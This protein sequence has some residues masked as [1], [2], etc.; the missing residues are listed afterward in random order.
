MLFRSYDDKK[1]NPYLNK[2]IGE[3]EKYFEE[4]FRYGWSQIVYWTEGSEQ[5]AHL[6]KADKKTI[7]TSITYL[8]DDYTG[9]ETYLSNEF[10]I[11]PKKGRTIFFHGMKYYH[12][13]S[14]IT[15]GGRYTLPIWYNRK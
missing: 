15:K 11:K 9:G 5:G 14:Q 2:I 1:I 10:S 4:D 12:G 6:D 3:C 7:I 8:N 13:V